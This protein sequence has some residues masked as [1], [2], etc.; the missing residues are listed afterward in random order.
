MQIGFYF[1]QTRCCGCFTCIVACKDWND[2]SAGPASWRRVMTLEKG[3]FPDLFVSYLSTSCHHCKEPSC[4]SVCPV[5]AIS[6]RESDGVV[7]VDGEICLGREDCGQCLEACPYEAPQFGAEE[8]AKMQKC[9]FCLDR[10]E[11]DRKPACVDS[12][13]MRALDAGPMD[14]LRERYGDV[15]EAEGFLYEGNL[16]PSIVFNPKKDTKGLAVKKVEV[17]P[18]PMA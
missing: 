6:K 1:D 15:R 10:L 8:N 12:C 9:H 4:L 7:V 17:S 11:N 5:E 18:R 3:T 2:V 14:E 16:M 13:P